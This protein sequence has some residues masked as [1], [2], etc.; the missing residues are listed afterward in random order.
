MHGTRLVE[1]SG[2]LCCDQ[3]HRY[4][5]TGGIPRFVE[6][7][8]YA[9]H[10]GLQ[11]KTYT[12]T[13]LDSHTG[14]PITRERLRRCFGQAGWSGLQG[15]TVLECGCGAGRFT[16]ILLERGAF[17]TSIDLSAAVEAN[18]ANFPIGPSHR[19]AQADILSLP[20][21][22]ES[23]DAVL[24][25]GVIQHT[26]N[27]EKT[28]AQLFR[29]VKP[30]GTLVIDHY[31][32]TLRRYTAAAPIFRAYLKRLPLD[33]ALAA[34][35]RLVDI[36][37]PLHKRFARPSLGRALLTR[38]SPVFSYYAEYPQLD[39]TQ[40][41]EWALLDTHDGL[42][43]WYKHV[44]TRRQIRRTLQALG[45]EDIWCEYGGNGVEARGRRPAERR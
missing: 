17:V 41:R 22:E 40:Q 18:K 11:W 16:E 42:T 43:D 31:A 9:E 36:F 3:N 13:Q 30:G 20:F 12:R 45:L 6:G 5:V 14:K 32:F 1:N 39:D 29:R 4:P 26:P 8:A 15:S 7:G 33:R 19:I 27:P 44:R 10:F 23:F 35:E 2:F 34:T 37:L 21:A 38:I 24:C 25:L 28:I